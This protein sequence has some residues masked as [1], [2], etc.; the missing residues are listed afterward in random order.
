[1]QRNV[2]DRGH[3]Q[4]GRAIEPDGPVPN[5]AGSVAVVAGQMML[6]RDFS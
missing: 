6:G 1:M 3:W 5:E 2:L 4:L